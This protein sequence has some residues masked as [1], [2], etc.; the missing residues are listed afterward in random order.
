MAQVASKHMFDNINVPSQ[1]RSS[2]HQ[3][4]TMEHLLLQQSSATKATGASTSSQSKTAS[5]SKKKIK[6]SRAT[7]TST[8]VSKATSSSN[9]TAQRLHQEEMED[10][11]LVNLQVKDLVVLD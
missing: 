4:Q 9:A 8:K 5:K 1:L 11:L 7:P 3:V 10:Q 6:L 2:K